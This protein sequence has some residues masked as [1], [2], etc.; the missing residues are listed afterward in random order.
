M[1]DG[2]ITAQESVIEVQKSINNMYE[3]H[4]E[5]INQILDN[6]SDTDPISKT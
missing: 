5:T 6:D 1:K 2:V 4:Q 3:K